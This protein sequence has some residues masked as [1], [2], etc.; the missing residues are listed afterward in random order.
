MFTEEQQAVIDA[1]LKEALS[2]QA[3][4]LNT[5]FESRIQGL[6]DTNQAL[7]DEKLAEIA[8]K[9]A[10][11][12]EAAK[13]ANDFEKILQLETE[14]AGKTQADLQTQLQARNDLLIGNDQKLAVSGLASHMINNDAATNLLL[15][16]M[17]KS[18]F[19]DDG[20]IIRSYTDFNG[21]EVATDEAGFLEWAGKNDVMRNYLAGSKAQGGNAGGNNGHK[22][23]YKN[24]KD[25]SSQER[26]EFKQ[27]D[28]DGF[29]KSFQLIR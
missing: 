16:N 23:G 4:T 12:L 6:K 19:N 18:K 13:K 7:K 17:A 5:E 27:R 11:E 10:A 1:K 20:Q 2:A 26:L 14:K 29:K 9:E 22:Q 28:P 3:Q 24:P 8:A 25:M 21:Q 15:S